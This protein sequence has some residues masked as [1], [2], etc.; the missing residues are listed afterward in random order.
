M[1]TMTDDDVLLT[2]RDLKERK[3][4]PF[5]DDWTRRLVKEGKFP[6]PIKSQGERGIN[7]WLE[8]EIDSYLKDRAASR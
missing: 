6:K 4:W 7:L 3:G 5:S 1:M 8:S 2:F